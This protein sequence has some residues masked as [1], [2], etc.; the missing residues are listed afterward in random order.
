MQI[1]YV[2]SLGIPNQSVCNMASVAPNILAVEVDAAKAIVSHLKAQGL[3]G[4][5]HCSLK[6]LLHI[7]LSMSMLAADG[8]AKI[9]FVNLLQMLRSA[10]SCKTTQRF[11]CTRARR[12][13]MS[14]RMAWPGPRFLKDLMA[15][16]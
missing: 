4:A 12:A 11:F 6:V 16:W 8:L 7:A 10:E 13:A 5:H 15:A 3:N 2:E 14:W 9:T 1:S